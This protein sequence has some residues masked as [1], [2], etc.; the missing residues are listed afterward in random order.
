MDILNFTQHATS[1]EQEADG[2]LDMPA[3]LRRELSQ[4]L[5][6]YGIPTANTIR[7]RA[8][9]LAEIAS[10]AATALEMTGLTIMIGGAPYLMGP[11]EFALKGAGWTVLYSFSERVSEEVNGV[12]T[13]EFRHI[14]WVEA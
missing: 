10:D 7:H 8:N 13:T 5:T 2:V 3:V 4:A 6:F 14:G 1:P 12:K 9:L 11:L